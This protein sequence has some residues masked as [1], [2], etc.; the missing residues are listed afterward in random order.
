METARCPEPT[1]RT[2]V[3]S[4]VSSIHP[5]RGRDI[6][7]CFAAYDL[8]QLVR[9]SADS[10]ASFSNWFC[11]FLKEAVC[12]LALCAVFLCGVMVSEVVR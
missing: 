11:D 2:P 1:H 12:L 9:S 8:F 4:S 3:T 5:G 7:K 6:L 10:N